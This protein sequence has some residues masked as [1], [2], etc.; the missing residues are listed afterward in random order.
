[1]NIDVTLRWA[2]NCVNFYRIENQKK[3]HIALRISQKLY[4]QFI[5]NILGRRRVNK[6]IPD[7]LAPLVTKNIPPAHLVLTHLIPHILAHTHTCTYTIHILAP[8]ITKNIPPAHL[9][10]PVLHCPLPVMR[11]RAETLRINLRRK[12]HPRQLDSWLRFTAHNVFSARRTRYSR[13]G[14]LAFKVSAW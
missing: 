6:L 5:P 3:L 13:N 9:V 2:A 14:F 11:R 10:V 4:S 1:M 12:Q 7:I 8:L